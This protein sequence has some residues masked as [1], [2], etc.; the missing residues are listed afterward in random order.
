M[1][2]YF[3]IYLLPT[4]AF[5]F[6]LG[7]FNLSSLPAPSTLFSLQNFIEKTQLEVDTENTAGAFSPASYEE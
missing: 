4:L 7:I 5:I 3:A 2:S 6:Y 1:S